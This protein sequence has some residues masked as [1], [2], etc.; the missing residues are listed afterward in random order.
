MISTLVLGLTLTA[1]P[2]RGAIAYCATLT[3][4]LLIVSFWVNPAMNF[5]RSG[6]QLVEQVANSIDPEREVGWVAFKEQYLLQLR[7][8][9]V[10]FGHARW[11]AGDQEAFDAAKWLDADPRR[12]LI[13]DT[14]VRNL[15]FAEA[16]A[17]SV[18]SA[19]RKHWFLVEG[20]ADPVCV[21]NGKTNV[22]FAYIP[23]SVRPATER[24]STAHEGSLRTAR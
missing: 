20:H 4:V 24:L 17:E 15:C 18:G 12:Q 19:N 3:T 9:V 5:A 6:A 10:H 1:R 2:R 22:A 13:V 7:R 14:S 21:A 11:R 16:A 8:P 23:P